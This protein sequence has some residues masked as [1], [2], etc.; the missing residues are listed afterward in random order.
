MLAYSG[1]PRKVWRIQGDFIMPAA[2]ACAIRLSPLAVR[3]AS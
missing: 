3:Q 1:D 2:K